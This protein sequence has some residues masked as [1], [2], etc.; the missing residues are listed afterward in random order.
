MRTVAQYRRDGLNETN[1]NECILIEGHWMWREFDFDY[2]NGD[3]NS[4]ELETMRVEN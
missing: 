4:R 3:L 1:W 2:G